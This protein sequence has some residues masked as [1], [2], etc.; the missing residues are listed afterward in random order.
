MSL[1]LLHL[2]RQMQTTP[3]IGLRSRQYRNQR[4]RATGTEPPPHPVYAGVKRMARYLKR[5][6]VA[7][8][9]IKNPRDYMNSP[10]RKVYD[11]SKLSH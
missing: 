11:D 3:R 2:L 10:Q 1:P 8:V 4:L 7:P 6:G 5:Q 9:H